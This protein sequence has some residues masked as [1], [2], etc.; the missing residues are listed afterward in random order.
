MLKRIAALVLLTAMLLTGCVIPANDMSLNEE[1]PITTDETV[2]E[3]APE[4]T[5][6]PTPEPTPTPEEIYAGALDILYDCRFEEA[7]PIFEQLGDFENSVNYAQLCR[8]RI[9][10]A[11]NPPSR[12]IIGDARLDKEYENGA[13]YYGQRAVFYVPYE[14]DRDTQCFVFHPGG[15]PGENWLPYD[16]V[17]KYVQDTQPNAVMYFYHESGASVFEKN[18]RPTVE[19]LWDIAAEKGFVAHDVV[20]IGASAGCYPVLHG[21][22]RYYLDFGLTVS[23]A[24]LLDAGM[25][26][27]VPF[28]YLKDEEL[29]TIA[30][31]GTEL[32]LFE[33][34][35][36]R[37]EKEPIK[38]LLDAGCFV[39]IV[40]CRD[41]TH[42]RIAFNAFKFGV[43]DYALG[44]TDETGLKE[45]EYTFVNLSQGIKHS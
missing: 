23:R 13:L 3:A 26:W 29:N 33:Q 37:D 40:E 1:T 32:Y 4:P 15:N 8:D 9:E 10:Y 38:N 27:D 7:L 19:A 39:T 22:A 31:Q 6:I 42:N 35:G 34:P 41:K 2:P 30:E 24:L 11:A 14:C 21:A 5:P 36:V 25:E 20:V 12:T 28:A 18:C 17:Y 43:F 44:Y 16:W 45:G